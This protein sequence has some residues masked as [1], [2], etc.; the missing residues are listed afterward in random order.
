MKKIIILKHSRG[1]LANQ[2]WNYISIYACGLETGAQ[3][4]N[5]SFFEYHSYFNFLAKES[6]I[7]RFFSSWFKDSTNRRG[8]MHN[9]FWRNV[10]LGYVEIIKFFA[11]KNLVSSENERNQVVFLPPT[12]PLPSLENKKTTYFIGWLFRNPLGL[13]KFR[14]ELV[15][16]FAPNKIIEQKVTDII[17]PL[18]Q[19]FEK[20]VG[21]HIRQAD[22][23]T[24]KGGVYFINQTRVKE[25][26]DE[27]IQKNSMDK[28]KTLFLITSDGPV[29]ANIFRNLTTYISK[30][31]F[32][33]D[34]F[35]LS[36]TDIIIGSDSS[37]GAFASWY[38]N[39]PH[40]VMTKNFMDWGYYSNKKEY[41][42]NKYSKMVQY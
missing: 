4:Q 9:R 22:Y 37:F 12:S 25:I 26:I 40:I 20:I 30:E 6:L 13:R 16:A 17:M 3:V 28:N 15:S 5:P 29:E 8:S 2:L 24:F 7:T 10:Y 42:E 39:I 35:L 31:N 23:R 18:R 41:F 32:I 1:E 11:G 33:T 14:R 19:K 34:L 36:S 27:F 21:V 38:G